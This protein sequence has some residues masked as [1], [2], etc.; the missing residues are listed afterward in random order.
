MLA[1]V[2]CH[3]VCGLLPPGD[4]GDRGQPGSAGR[5]GF[6]GRQGLDGFPGP[7]GDLGPQVSV[8]LELNPQ[9]ESGTEQGSETQLRSKEF[10]QKS[11]VNTQM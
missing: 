9:H 4:K 10:N 3:A 8:A 5:R 1:T 6:P 7:L 11:N 2:W